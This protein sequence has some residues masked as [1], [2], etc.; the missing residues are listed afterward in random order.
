MVRL[1]DRLGFYSIQTKTII[2]GV[3]LPLQIKKKIYWIPEIALAWKINNL[4]LD[5]LYIP[6]TFCR[7]AS[8]I[9]ITTQIPVS[10]L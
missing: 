6:F 10:E 2:Q 5:R 7:T 8:F 9:Y 1:L 3:S 4:T